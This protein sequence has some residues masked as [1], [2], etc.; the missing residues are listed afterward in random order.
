ML[1]SA[2]KRVE[3]RQCLHKGHLRAWYDIFHNDFRNKLTT[4][5][6]RNAFTCIAKLFERLAI[7]RFFFSFLSALFPTGTRKTAT[8]T[9]ARSLFLYGEKLQT[10]ALSISTDFISRTIRSEKEVPS[11]ICTQRPSFT[12]CCTTIRLFHCRSCRVYFWCLHENIMMASE[13]AL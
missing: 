6:L 4:S 8:S 10:V 2:Q 3:V 12:A 5:Y 13:W 9:C 11:Q 1:S 7:Q